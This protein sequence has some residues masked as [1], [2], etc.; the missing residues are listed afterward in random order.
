MLNGHHGTAIAPRRVGETTMTKQIFA[1][2][3]I[4]ACGSTKPTPPT[5]NTATQSTA[6]AILADPAATRCGNP[7]GT[8]CPTDYACVTDPDTH[9]ELAAGVCAKMCKTNTDCGDSYVCAPDSGVCVLYCGPIAC[10]DY[11]TVNGCAPCPAPVQCPA[12]YACSPSAAASTLAICTRTC[13]AGAAMGNDNAC[14]AA[15]TCTNA[16]CVKD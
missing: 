10:P 7:T 5:N 8:T 16:V 12:G 9:G 6:A 15:Y 13:A 1:F 11:C 2:V 3:F 14:P 4:A